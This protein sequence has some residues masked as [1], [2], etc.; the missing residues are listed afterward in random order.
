VNRSTILVVDDNL[1]N[2]KLLRDL[3]EGEGYSVHVAYDEAE[4]LGVL[5]EELIDLVISDVLMPNSD[6]YQL[7]NEIRQS[8]KFQEIPII[9]YTATYTSPCDERLAL[10]LGADKYLRKPAKPAELLRVVGEALALEPRTPIAILPEF[11]VLKQY[12]KRTSYFSSAPR[13]CGQHIQNYSMSSSI[14]RR[15]C[16]L[17]GSSQSRLP[18][19]L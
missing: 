16:I 7:C 4:A 1:L 5:D 8:E 19:R 2:I 6:G 15:L 9:I 11:E 18:Y 17:S 14:V 12:S 10:D 3:L 13:N